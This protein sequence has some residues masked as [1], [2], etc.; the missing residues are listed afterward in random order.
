MNPKTVQKDSMQLIP[1]MKEAKRKGQKAQ[2]NWLEKASVF[3]TFCVPGY[4]LLCTIAKNAKKNVGCGPGNFTCEKILPLLPNTTKKLIGVDISSNN[5][6]YAR[7]HYQTDPRISFQQLDILTENIPGEFVRAFD[8]VI[9]LYCLHFVGNH[10]KAIANMYKM[11]K[12]G[13][14]ILISVPRTSILTNTY[15][16]VYNNPKWKKYMNNFNDVV[17]QEQSEDFYKKIFKEIGFEQFQC[18]QEEKTFSYLEE[19]MFGLLKSL[20]LFNMPARLEK[21]FIETQMEY[22]QS[23]CYVEFDE[24]GQQQYSFPYVMV[25]INASKP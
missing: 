8:L 3:L 25:V 18:E 9:S 14:K 15:Q 17:V 21:E 19:S 7:K 13:G 6:E 1:L 2:I 24:K 5:I 22:L 20:N 23:N 4:V 16:V 10:K 12:D 11:L